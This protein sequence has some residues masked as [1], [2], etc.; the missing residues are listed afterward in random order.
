MSIIKCPECQDLM[1][2]KAKKCTH[3]GLS[4]EHLSYITHR[5]QDHLHPTYG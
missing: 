3:C 1:S 5:E 4:A 2:D